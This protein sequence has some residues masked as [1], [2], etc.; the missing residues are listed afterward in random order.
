M[1][2]QR[3]NTRSTDAP[4]PLP[5]TCD[6]QSIRIYDSQHGRLSV[7]VPVEVDVVLN[8]SLSWSNDSKHLFALSGGKIKC[9]NVPTGTT[10]SEWPIRSSHDP[11]GIALARNGRFIAA[12]TNSSLS[13]WD[14]ATRIQIGPIIKHTGTI[15]SMAISP[16]YDLV[17]GGKLVVLRSLRDILPSPCFDEESA[18]IAESDG[19]R[20]P[21]S[22][23]Q[24]D[25]VMS[26]SR[27]NANPEETIKSL[28]IDIRD[29]REKPESSR[30]FM[31]TLARVFF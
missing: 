31:G 27:E 29:L 16:D 12:S 26:I 10:L 24:I 17:T 23:G 14:T 2:W 11:E 13:F 8:Q 30:T 22:N 6:T 9:L 19:G 18:P 4:L 1:A 3:S 20:W 15:P 28:L 25:W 5:L 21:S 7:S